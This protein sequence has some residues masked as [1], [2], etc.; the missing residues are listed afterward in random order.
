M[1]LQTCKELYHRDTETP[2]HSIPSTYSS[3]LSA[4]AHLLL[5]TIYINS[6]IFREDINTV[7]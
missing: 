6:K 7:L 4:W 3:C 5:P 2:A 1:N